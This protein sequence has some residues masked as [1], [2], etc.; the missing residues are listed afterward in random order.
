M[1]ALVAA[2]LLAL[3]NVLPASATD[4]R[5]VEDASLRAVH[6]VDENE[7]WAV[8]DEG[9]IWHTIDGG[10]TWERQKTGV[11]ASL[12]SVVF[13][14]P[15]LGWAVG[16]EELPHGRGSVGVL[17]FTRDGGEKWQ[18]LLDNALPGLNQV[19]F[20]DPKTGFVLGDG[21]EQFSTGV[22]RTNDGGRTWE[23]VPGPR[24]TSWRAGVFAKD[25][26][27][28]LGG[29]WSSLAKMSGDTF[30]K[31]EVDDLGGR[32]ITGLAILPGKLVA[33]GQGGLVL[34]SQSGGARYGFADL[35]LPTEVLACLDFHGIHAVGPRA[36]AVGRPGSVVLH[37]ADAGATWSLQ[38][39]G[40][41]LPL[42]G[43]YFLNEQRG[44]AVGDLGL[45]LTTSDGGKTWKAQRQG[46][47]RAAASLVHA[48]STDLPLDVLAQL[49]ADE[50]YLLHALNLIAPD[51]G[52]AN[53]ARALEAQRFAAATRRAGGAVAE[54][55]WQFPLP[56]HLTPSVRTGGKDAANEGMLDPRPLLAHWNQY[57]GNQASGEILRQLVLA[58]RIWRPD[59]L[60]TSAPPPKSTSAAAALVAEA[61]AEAVRCAAD[62]KQFPEQVQALSLS[63]WS[64]KKLY[65]L[66]DQPSAHVSF[67]NHEPRPR[68]VASA[69]DYAS[70]AA[71]ILSE[72]STPWPGQRHYRL[73]HSTLEGAE[74][75]KHLFQGLVHD[76][77]QTRRNVGELEAKIDP[78]LR[79]AVQAS[80]HLLVLADKIDDGKT[81]AQIG[82]ALAGLPEEHAARAAFA[83]ASQYARKG[84]WH[85]AR[86]AF[87]LLV[88]R[89]PSHPL[90]ADAYRWLIRHISSSEA[91]RRHELGQ[92]YMV[93]KLAFNPGL[94]SNPKP[95][96]I[97]QVKGTNIEV[98]A[99][100]RLTFLSNRDEIRHWFKGSLEIGKRLAAFGPLYATDPA[101]QFCLQ[102]SRRQLG[103]FAAAQDWY[104]KYQQFGPKGPYHD[105]AAAELW[106]VNRGLNQPRKV[107]LCRFTAEKP[108]LDGVFD[109]P[110]WQGVKPMLLDNAVGSTTKQ[111]HTEVRLACDDQYLY[112]AL[113]CLHPDGGFVPAVKNRSRDANLDAF[114]RVSILLDLDRDYSTY[115]RLEVDQ[116]GC[117][118]E[119]CWGD[120][121]WN[122]KW[123]VAVKSDATS[124]HIEAAVPLHELTG[125]RVTSN[126][127]WAFNAVRVLPG[128]GVQSW[129]FPADAEPRPEGMS[130]LLFQS[131]AKHGPAQTMPKAK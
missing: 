113:R 63:A 112:L 69:G 39:T 88:D 4:L 70:A 105:A 96:E 13:L 106:L 49:G 130:L 34:T 92:F 71:G 116:R 6:F 95:G 31:A 121:S 94:D 1:R 129:S 83:I 118:R 14:N 81:L 114:D 67:D 85:L 80:H 56:L 38:P 33:V 24:S 98:N 30:N 87:L 120:P 61:L 89:Y 9:A 123:F 26:T 131:D 99:A 68:L 45:I 90:A 17:L 84:Q 127:A 59:V 101:I 18:R 58:L 46:G 76:K 37:T 16:R 91:R 19:T 5:Y 29:A 50:G 55:L 12:R 125:D 25:H 48:Q 66:A 74:R 103:D 104:A 79:K 93:D 108:Y 40:Q 47:K 115:F 43:V 53:P 126:T 32:S 110:C 62:P 10:Q 128:R 117:V 60:L 100:S 21:A 44:W 7:G 119:D 51:A 15:F 86:E 122:P 8:G 73:A 57:H 97:Q 111:Y 64:V 65:V 102:S 3:L 107:A 23:P 41:P 35:K 75:Q 124:W 2:C 72:P 11:R 28:F 78:E 54:A 82:P 52:S 42:H 27:G 36:W 109:E 20:L 77:G 22:F